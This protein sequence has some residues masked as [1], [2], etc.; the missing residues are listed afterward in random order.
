M[1]KKSEQGKEQEGRIKEQEKKIKDLEQKSEFEIEKLRKV[2]SLLKP[3]LH[4]FVMEN[5]SEEKK[6]DLH[7]DW[8][9]PSMYT[10]Q[11]GYKFCIG[12][13]PNGW[14]S[15]QNIGVNVDLWAM[16]GDYDD[17]LEWPAEVKFTVEL[18]NHFTKGKNRSVE[19]TH[20]WNKPDV[21]TFFVGSFEPNPH[22]PKTMKIF[23]EHGEL[24][25]NPDAKTHFLWKDAL[26][27]IITKITQLPKK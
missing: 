20:K 16:P 4:T 17:Q 10:H 18:V 6:K 26:Y 23:I 3:L 8:K 9:S 5:F 12:I 24:E 25:Y 27:F 11:H 1:D 22:N 15:S 7:N 2:S 13:D 21:L 14:Q 19:V